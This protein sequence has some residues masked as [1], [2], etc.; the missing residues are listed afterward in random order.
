MWYRQDVCRSSWGGKRVKIGGA[1]VEILKVV[2]VGLESELAN[3]TDALK[4]FI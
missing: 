4:S 2:K 3:F 1:G